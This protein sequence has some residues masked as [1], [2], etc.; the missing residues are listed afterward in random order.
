M[1]FIVVSALTLCTIMHLVARHEA[2]YGLPKTV[3]ISAIVTVGGMLIE[4]AIGP[5]VVPLMIAFT[6]WALHH[7]CYL[8][9]RTSG[10]V[11]A[12]YSLSMI[13]LQLCYMAFTHK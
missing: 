3:L 4:L 8:T 7:F 12:I 5:F 9:W 6:L 11:T 1:L 13:G 2:D 10:I